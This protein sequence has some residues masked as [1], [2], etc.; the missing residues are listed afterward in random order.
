MTLQLL[1]IN[2]LVLEKLAYLMSM[3][4]KMVSTSVR[5]G[6]KRRLTKSPPYNKA[7]KADSQR[8]AASVQSLV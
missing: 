3:Q 4:R 5:F 1:Y 6:W 7:F 2:V 8:L